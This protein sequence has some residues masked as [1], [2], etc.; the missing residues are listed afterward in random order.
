MQGERVLLNCGC[1][2]VG[3]AQLYY[4]PLGIALFILRHDWLVLV[5]H[6]VLQQ[7]GSALFFLNWLLH[8]NLNTIH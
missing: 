4:A 5:A 3:L 7:R 2:G 6:L 8:T 1:F